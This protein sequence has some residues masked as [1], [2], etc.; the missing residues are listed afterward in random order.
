M[1]VSSKEDEAANPAI[2]SAEG[3]QKLLKSVSPHPPGDQVDRLVVL[4]HYIRSIALWSVRVF[5]I[6]LLVYAL[7]WLIGSFWEGILP[8]ILALIVCTVLAPF[9]SWLRRHRF[10]ASLAAAI[11]MLTFVSLVG[12]L[13]AFIAPDF[14]RQS[15]SLYLQTVE[16]IQRLQLWAQGPPLNLD[17]DD[18]GQYID[19]IASWLLDRDNVPLS[20]D[21]SQLQP[22]Q[23]P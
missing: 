14:A 4:G 11:T 2:T 21:P 15:Q 9:A 17:S 6:G 7:G 3:Q 22:L 16:G 10:P 12:G 23:V 1:D 13:V 8:V 20:P 5:V 19:D 18:M